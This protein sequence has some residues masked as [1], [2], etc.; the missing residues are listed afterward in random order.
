ILIVNPTL[1]DTEK[2]LEKNS[3]E[4]VNN[5]IAG[6]LLVG[7]K[8][9]EPLPYR[10][11]YV[12]NKENDTIQTVITGSDGNFTIKNNLP[13]NELSINIS[14]YPEITGTDKVYIA[15]QKGKVIGVFEKGANGF[16]Y[17]FLNRDIFVLRSLEEEDP[18]M[19]LLEFKNRMFYTHHIF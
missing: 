2:F 3:A 4:G 17:K 1:A 9:L 12:T 18:G 6:K 19:A 5:V 16:S 13:K 15:T 11:I 10:K 14:R 8:T 7:A